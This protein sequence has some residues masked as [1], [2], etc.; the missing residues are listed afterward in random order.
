[1]G[2]GAGYELGCHGR[3]KIIAQV[4]VLGF[5]NIPSLTGRKM[6]SKDP[7]FGV[8]GLWAQEVLTAGGNSVYVNPLTGGPGGEKEGREVH[9]AFR[10]K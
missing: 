10:S 8:S 4:I 7:Q 3:K 5:P 9:F 6:G 1:M 2:V